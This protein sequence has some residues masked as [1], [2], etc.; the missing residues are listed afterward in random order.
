ME[1]ICFFVPSL[2]IGGIENVFITY[3]NELADRG[4]DVRF[5]LCH[6]EG[7]LL[8]LVSKSV[9]IDDLGNCSLRKAFFPLRRYLKRNATDILITGGDYPNLMCI[10]GTRFLKKKPKVIISKH[11]YRNAETK[12]L[13]WWS[14][15]D[16]KL[17][18]TLYPK[19][20]RIIAVSNGIKKY[21]MGAL[22][23]KSARVDV[24]PNPIDMDEITRKSEQKIEIELP[25]K[26]VVFVGRISKVK[27][28][29]FL[30]NSFDRIDDNDLHLVIV[31]D[32]AEKNL[33]EEYSSQKKS[34]DRI[35]FMGSY[36]NP[37]PL[38]KEA[39]A[40]V[41]CSLSEAYP[42]ILLE[43]MTLNVPIVT[44]PTEGAKEILEG[45]EGAYISKSFTD[46]LTFS[47]LIRNAVSLDP[48]NLEQYA[49]NNKKDN[50]VDKFE[51]ILLTIS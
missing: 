39:S 26:Y 36:S 31:G 29:R 42:T 10:L 43:A 41:L 4:Y 45:V 50:V 30:I 48:V 16:Q 11:N 37:M 7:D 21:L 9:R 20:D 49:Y 2:N 35:H 22:K 18:E 13:G 12:D 38:L 5:V 1:R 15:L 32:G 6:R 34:F 19:A 17:Q 44:T 40:L 8:P 46:E 47:E 51:N 33:L 28:L 3:A 23:I 14:F 27:N 25:Q 24:I